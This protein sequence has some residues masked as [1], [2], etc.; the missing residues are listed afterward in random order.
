MP[1]SFSSFPDND[2]L[3]PALDENYAD[4]IVEYREN[5]DRLPDASIP[6]TI[7]VIDDRYAVLYVPLSA[8]TP[9]TISATDYSTIPKCYAAMDLPSLNSSGI[10]RL[11]DHPY[12]HLTG[13][14]TAVAIIDSGIDYTLPVFQNSDGTTRIAWLWDQTLTK[15]IADS[16]SST[17]Q[18]EAS[19]KQSLADFASQHTPV[20]S[21]NETP[22]HSHATRPTV[23]YGTVFSAA[24]INRALASDDPLAIVPSTD[25]TGH[26]TFLS[27]IAAGKESSADNF[28][29]VAPDASLI[30]VRLKPAKQ[31]LRDL[32]LLPAS[33]VVY[34]ENDIMLAISFA[35]ACSGQMG[36]LPVSLC[37][38][39]GTSL[40]AH[41]GTGPLEQYADRIA[42]QMG[43]CIS[44]AAGNEGNARHHYR[45]AHTPEKKEDIAELRVAEGET[46]FSLELVGRSLSPYEVTLQSPSGESARITPS[47]F[48]SSSTIRYIFTQSTIYVTTIPLEAQ[49]GAQLLF[50]RFYAPEAGLWRITVSTDTQAEVFYDLW[51]PVQGLV[52]E[53]TYFL[54]STPLQTITAPGCALSPI[55]YTAYDYRNS[56]LY[57]EASRGFTPIMSIKPDLAAP[58][59]ALIGPLPKGRFSTRSGTSLAAAHG[60]GAAA[61]FFEWSL[62][63]QN[64]PSL[65]GLGVKNFFIRSARRSAD[66]S[67]PTREWGYGILDLYNTF[68]TLF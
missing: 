65:N 22:S 64:V 10:T 2:S 53:N 14:G 45:G 11:S 34:Q 16:T 18:T 42:R 62:V 27:G 58:G 39:L 31:Y 6:H 3:P 23:P 12:L 67:Y 60:A 24:D 46:G 5:P 51:L 50:L 54:R 38:G 63:R 59:V 9:E 13:Q 15:A 7:S 56:S 68:S 8:F 40:G 61:L 29:G 30:I 17:S 35:L 21:R 47:W 28:R 48:N 4:F 57:L 37:I 55:T 41:S 44:M 20:N 1:D 49:S 32:F 52:K 33:A 66:L 36:G 43:V 19:P 26:G 25:A